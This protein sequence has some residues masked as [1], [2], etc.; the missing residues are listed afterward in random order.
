MLHLKVAVQGNQLS[1]CTLSTL[2]SIHMSYHLM[3]YT[4]AYFACKTLINCTKIILLVDI[5]LDK[6]EQPSVQEVHV[7]DDELRQGRL[8]NIK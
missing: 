1:V 3:S 5:V 2:F 4:P 6:Q 8:L 7:I